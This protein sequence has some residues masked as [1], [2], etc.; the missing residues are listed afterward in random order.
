[1]GPDPDKNNIGCL[2]GSSPQTARRPERARTRCARLRKAI[3]QLHGREHQHLRQTSVPYLMVQVQPCVGR[4]T[5]THSRW[6]SLGG[7]EV[8]QN[9]LTT[10]T[11]R[12]VAD[13][14]SCWNHPH[15]LTF[16][17]PL[18]WPWSHGDFITLPWPVI[19]NDR[20]P[21]QRKPEPRQVEIHDEFVSLGCG[22]NTTETVSHDAEGDNNN[23][24]DVVCLCSLAHTKNKEPRRSGVTLCVLPI[25]SPCEHS[26]AHLVQ[27]WL[28]RPI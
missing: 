4:G 9:R 25:S 14:L 19:K 6:V 23:N 1:M 17:N 21:R 11:Y 28:P 27:H 13:I 5:P 12:A 16:T 24:A 10:V 22:A 20:H 26:E 7:S 15:G 3:S 2:C 8:S 18:L